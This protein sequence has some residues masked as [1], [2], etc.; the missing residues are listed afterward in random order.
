MVQSNLLV[1]RIQLREPAGAL[2][3]IHT[4]R[5]TRQ[6]LRATQGKWTWIVRHLQSWRSRERD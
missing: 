5:A 4:A 2:S 1:R 3:G 6:A